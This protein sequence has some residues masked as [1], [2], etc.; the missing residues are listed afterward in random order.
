MA[1]PT[2]KS[3]DFIINPKLGKQIYYKSTYRTIFG[4]LNGPREVKTTKIAHDDMELTIDSGNDSPVWEKNF[5]SG[6]E[7]RFT[8]LEEFRGMATYGAADVKPGPFNEYMHSVCYV[9]QIDSPTGPLVDSESAELVKDVIDDLVRLKK[10]NM[11][12]W[13]SKEVD[14]DAF[15]A[16]F[17]GASRGILATDDGGLGVSLTGGTAGQQ[18]APYNVYVEG[19]ANL[20]TPSATLSTHNSNVAT[21]LDT[22]SDNK[23]YAFTYTSHKHNA[24]QIERLYFKPVKIGR[25]EYRAVALIDQRNIERMFAVEGT[26]STLFQNAEKRGMQNPALNGMRT[27][28]LDD[29]LYIPVRQ[30]EFFRPTVETDDSITWGA[31]LDKD[32]RSRSF[33]NSSCLCPTVYMGAGGLLRGRR[34]RVWVTVEK[35]RH[36]K[37]LEYCVH[38]HDGWMRHDK[39]SKDD[40]NIMENDSMLVTFNYDPGVGK[41]Y[42][43]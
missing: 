7:C 41:S 1:N 36:G 22:L 39:F 32:P 26:L 38:Y 31:G 25:Q 42:A 21:A 9:R 15:R 37:G 17:T 6:N 11:E 4:K 20:V 3:T 13:R 24:Y 35:G 43:A 28:V 23:N 19:Q 2:W 8:T 29:I 30:L 18:R 12:L 14:L 27:L 10:N 16:I 5:T 40:R 34:K 33:S